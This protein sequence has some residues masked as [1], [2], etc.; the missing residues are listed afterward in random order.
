VGIQLGMLT[1]QNINLITSY[2]EALHKATEEIPGIDLLAAKIFS[3]LSNATTK[4]DVK[5]LKLAADAPSWL[6]SGTKIYIF[7][8]KTQLLCNHAN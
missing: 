6:D 7:K 1:C 2:D 4:D 3:S 8:P 5:V